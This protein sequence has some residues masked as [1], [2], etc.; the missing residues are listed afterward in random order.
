V[1]TA[2][3]P[4]V[5]IDSAK[6]PAIRF[7]DDSESYC[8]LLSL[9]T[10]PGDEGEGEHGASAHSQANGSGAPAP[11]RPAGRSILGGLRQSASKSIDGLTCRASTGA[12]DVQFIT[13]LNTEGDAA[14]EDPATTTDTGTGRRLT[15]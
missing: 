7:E 3:S 2:R 8:D 6:A 14:L 5:G 11:G 12:G 9:V 10:A 15:Q 1:S 4:S 13:D